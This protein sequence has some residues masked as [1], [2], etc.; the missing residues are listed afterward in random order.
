MINI[1]YVITAS[2]L[3]PVSDQL[4]RVL[5]RN[6]NP[7]VIPMFEKYDLDTIRNNW[8]E[9][10]VKV[11]LDLSLQQVVSVV[12]LFLLQFIVL[13]C[14]YQC[15]YSENILSSVTKHFEENID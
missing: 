5:F 14:H 3:I 13:D 11:E 10:A 8:T 15:Y 4:Y 6:Y 1:A 12:N 9:Y 2:R 7:D